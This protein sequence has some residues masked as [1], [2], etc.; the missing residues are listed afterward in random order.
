MKEISIIGPDTDDEDPARGSHKTHVLIDPPTRVIT[1]TAKVAALRGLQEFEFKSQSTSSLDKMLE[2]ESFTGDGHNPIRETSL[3]DHLDGSDESKLYY[4]REL[5]KDDERQLAE[6]NI[7]HD[8]GYAVAVCLALD[9]KGQDVDEQTELIV[10]DGSGEPIHEPAWG[11]K[12]F[13]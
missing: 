9:Q 13:L 4:R 1:M 10:D 11:D 5:V 8:G 12:G 6:L 3:P 7:S 2:G